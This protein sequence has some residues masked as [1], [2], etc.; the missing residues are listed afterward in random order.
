M[1]DQRSIIIKDVER[2]IRQDDYHN[3]YIGINIT[4]VVLAMIRANFKNIED[5]FGY[6]CSYEDAKFIKDYLV[7][8]GMK[9]SSRFDKVNSKGVFLF[10]D[11]DDL[12]HRM[13]Q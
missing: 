7:K 10:R 1:E 8:K 11:P 12:S 5:P 13:P 4:E 6:P 9:S 3:Y 2:R